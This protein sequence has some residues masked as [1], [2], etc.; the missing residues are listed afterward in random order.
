MSS[1][2]IALLDPPGVSID[3]APLRSL[4]SRNGLWTLGALALR[5]GLE[6]EREWLAGILWPDA[7]RELGLASLRR[8]LTDLRAALGHY[9]DRITA[10]TPHSLCLSLRES[11]LDITEFDRCITAGDEE[12]LKAA[13]DLY[14]GA[15]IEC[16]KEEWIVSARERCEQD[17]ILD[18]LG[19]LVDCSLLGFEES[20]SAP[21]CRMLETVRTY[22]AD[23]IDA[24]DKMVECANRHL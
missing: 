21:R 12:S 7:P 5:R 19:E 6:V 13:V 18:T 15:L 16:C 14:K 24:D 9:A 2:R 17:Y 23:K 8:T 3:G 11:E 22:L 1:L 10:P 4:R 20:Q